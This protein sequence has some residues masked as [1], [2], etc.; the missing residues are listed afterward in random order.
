[1]AGRRSSSCWSGARS[2]RLRPTRSCVT[3]VSSA[4][5]N[6]AYTGGSSRAIGNVHADSRSLDTP[7]GSPLCREA[8]SAATPQP[9]N[10]PKA[11]TCESRS[12]VVATPYPPTAT[13][14]VTTASRYPRSGAGVAH[15][16]QPR[17]QP[18]SAARARGQRPGVA[19][20]NIMT[21]PTA[22]AL[23]GDRLTHCAP[24]LLYV[25]GSSRTVIVTYSSRRE[26][27]HAQRQVGLSRPTDRPR[28]EGSTAMRSVK[29]ACADRPT[30]REPK[31]AP[32][33][34]ASSGPEP[35]D[36]PTASRAIEGPGEQGSSQRAKA[37]GA[38][39]VEGRSDVLRHGPGQHDPNLISRVAT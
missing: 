39:N 12:G 23:T 38:G 37:T 3:A 7:A 15:T 26:H 25:L 27:R 14:S 4:G 21:L 2:R 30:D 33:C 11:A 22:G 24:F 35:T 9:T 29:W 17:I 10:S 36:R 13:A 32:P 28:A 8:S 1:M 5:A 16:G 19:G 31:G 20:S 34:A 18:V 6:S